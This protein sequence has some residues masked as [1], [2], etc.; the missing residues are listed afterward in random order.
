MPYRSKIR[1]AVRNDTPNN[2]SIISSVKVQKVESLPVNAG[3]FHAEYRQGKLTPTGVDY[4]ILDTQG[5]KGKYVG[6]YIVMQSAPGQG[7]VNFLEGDETI[8]VDDEI[9]WPS[10][11]VGTGTEDYFSGAY[12]WNAVDPKDM[13]KPFGGILFRDD[14]LRR[15]CAYRWH[16]TDFVAFQKRVKVDLEHGGV[17]EWPNDYSS[18]GFWYMDKPV[19]AVAIP[20]LDQRKLRTEIMTGGVSAPM[21]M[22][23]E[24]RGTFTSEGTQLEMR[25]QPEEAQVPNNPLGI[26][27]GM[28]YIQHYCKAKDIGQEIKGK[29]FVPGEDSYQMNA[30]FAV[31]PN[32]GKFSVYIG[33]QYV[34][35]VDMFSEIYHPAKLL[36][37]GSVI[38]KE[39]EHDLVFKA[40]GKDENATGMDF[41]LIAWQSTPKTAALIRKWRLCGPFPCPKEGGWD[42]ANPPEREINFDTVYEV[43]FDG[44]KTKSQ[45]KW[46]TLDLPPN[47]GVAS[48]GFYG[49]FPWQCCYAVTYIWA[50]KD[51]VA[52]AFI[53]K[54][55]AL[56][57][58]VNDQIV[59]NNNSWSHYL[60][61]QFIAA[62]PL[63]AGWNKMLVK[64]GNWDGMWAF[65]I[66]L[67]DINGELKFS[68]DKPAQ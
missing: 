21:M 64:N 8:Y 7:G 38:L 13:D 20:P 23:S 56:R 39:G 58:W 22:G 47:A 60:G 9:K 32:Y 24:F 48:G 14:N 49:Q 46:M 10:R 31:G 28:P 19:D 18:V 11:Y 44:G 25:R 51:M 55:D 4:T 41:G 33:G 67:T 63:K 17:S 26:G 15:V 12:Y 61:D 45:A 37:V 50:P 3:Y 42:T 53:A 40:E 34:G 27:V 30:F 29:L 5:G 68:N 66:R 65:A 36:S 62:C 54:D 59:F 2:A 57:I 16:I 52:G 1:I 35:T 43:S 6:C